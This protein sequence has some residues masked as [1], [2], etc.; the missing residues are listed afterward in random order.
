MTTLRSISRSLTR[1]NY[2]LSVSFLFILHVEFF[3]DVELGISFLAEQSSA[4]SRNANQLECLSVCINNGKK[5][6][7][8]V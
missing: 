1:V 5:F 4:R 6:P 7:H 8:P 3:T 2:N